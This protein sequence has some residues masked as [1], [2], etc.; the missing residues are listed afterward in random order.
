MTWFTL[1]D[2]EA[3]PLLTRLTSI[4]RRQGRPTPGVVSAMKANPDAM[5]ALLQLNAQITFGS[6]SLGRYR[7]ELIATTTSGLNQ[8]FY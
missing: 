7:E 4:Y 8:C 5:R 1:P 6:S 3:T 2:D